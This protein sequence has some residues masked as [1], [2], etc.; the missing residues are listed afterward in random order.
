M[1][2]KKGQILELEVSDLAFG[3]KGFASHDGLAIFVDQAV[4][5]DRV[6]AR[7][8]KKKKKHAE[9][10]VLE[11]L[12]SSSLRIDPPCPYSGHCGGCKWQFLDYEKQL[13][14]KQRHVTES[15][16]HIGLI[17]DVP[18]HPTIS[19]DSVFG[20]R[21]KMEFSI[22][23]WRWLMSHEMGIEGIDTSFALGL[24]VP[25]TFYKVLD[26]SACLLQPEPGNLILEDVRK[27]MK[28]S[29]LPVYGLR[30]HVGFWR[31][32]MLRNSAF[33]GKWMVNIITSK[34]DE[35][36][37]M[38][39]A[40]AL[41][42]SWPQVSSVVNNVTSKKAG[43]AFGE[44]EIGLS[45]ESVLREKIGRFEFEISAN[46]FFQTNT[47]GAHLLYKTVK[48]YAGLT[49]DENVLDLYCGTG[50]ISIFLSDAA[51]KITGMEIME[52][53][54]KD[55]KN[56]CRLNNIEN[57][58]FIQGD[59]RNNIADI[60]NTPDVIIIDPPRAGMHKDVVNSLIQLGSE[61]IVYVSCNPATLARDLA[62][63]KDRYRI[64]EIQP[65]DMFPHT[66]HIES[67]AKLSKIV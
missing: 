34:E 63:F 50:T 27:Y 6:S 25:G 60:K 36:N 37:L 21:N 30:S 32:L 13:E 9:A 22:S 29:G 58:E 38:P 59:I 18:V 23:D 44:Y 42:E 15:I 20:Y 66:W 48:E 4:P 54:I 11:L 53:S 49:G 2:V 45:G 7:I 61:R 17:K 16:E 31:F 55:A 35:K 26:I 3:G 10:R 28:N 40:N 56:N 57:C 41:R 52:S 65:V 62:M 47:K 5:G 1:K 12:S 67:V 33:D 46:S 64:L 24:H 8:V 19:S 14:Y 39:L 43:I 51:K